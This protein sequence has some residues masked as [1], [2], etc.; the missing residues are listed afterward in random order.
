MVDHCLL[1]LGRAQPYSAVLP[2][3]LWSRFYLVAA[4]LAEMAIMLWLLI[5]GAN[6][7]ALPAE[8]P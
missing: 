1:R 6:V 8:A 2:R 3:V 4:P 5:R 7:K